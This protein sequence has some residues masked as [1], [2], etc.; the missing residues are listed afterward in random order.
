MI[1]LAIL[2]LLI[3]SP[4]LAEERCKNNGRAGIIAELA[5]EYGE[6]QVLE[7]LDP[8]VGVIVEFYYSAKSG[9]WTLL[10]TFTDGRTC[11]M[12]S[13]TGVTIAKQGEPL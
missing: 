3:A 8:Q 2:A 10:S 7:A 11:M 13:G 9:T 5:K 4:A 6:T 12:G 1:R